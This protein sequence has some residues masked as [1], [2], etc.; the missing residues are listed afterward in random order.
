MVDDREQDEIV[1]EAAHGRRPREIAK[2]RGLTVA[3]VIQA[4]DDAA[5]RAFS[6]EELRRELLLEVHRLR[7]IER[8]HFER[9]DEVSSA[10]VYLKSSERLASLIGMNQPIGMSV[11]LIHAKQIEQ[12]ESSTENLRRIFEEVRLEAQAKR[13]N[14]GEGEPQA[15]R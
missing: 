6:G 9:C 10:A 8:K 3:A 15:N 14:G 5:K 13:S 12:H 4:L 7:E 11:Q 2:A 1:H